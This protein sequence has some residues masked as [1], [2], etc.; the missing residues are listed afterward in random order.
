MQIKE[1][2]TSGDE[3]ISLSEAKNWLKIDFTT[4]D[5]LITMIITAVREFA[6]NYTGL[7]LI[8][9]TIEYF[10]EAPKS[11]IVLPF[12][13][14]SSITEVKINNVV[15]TGYLKTG[16]TQFII[17]ISPVY[18]SSTENDNGLYVKYE[19]TGTCPTGLKSLMLKEIDEQYRNRGNTFEGSI[20]D[21]SANFYASAAKYCLM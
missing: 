21:L 10:D 9:K 7:S 2:I 5:D 4:D 19:T 11:K 8:A 13:E 15:T 16:L 18:Q 1:T 3:P 12:P 14:H 6:E 17:D 20:V